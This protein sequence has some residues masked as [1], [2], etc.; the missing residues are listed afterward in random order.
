[1]RGG[2]LKLTVK[3]AAKDKGMASQEIRHLQGFEIGTVTF[4]AEAKGGAGPSTV[5]EVSYHKRNAGH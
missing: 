3:S 5:P 4:K 2:I 1:M